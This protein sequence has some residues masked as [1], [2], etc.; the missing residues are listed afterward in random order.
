MRKKVISGLLFLVVLLPLMACRRSDKD[1]TDSFRKFAVKEVK[2]I[3]KGRG[4]VTASP[5]PSVDSD[6]KQTWGKCYQQNFE[7]YTIDVTK[8][9]SVVTPYIGSLTVPQIFMCTD[10]HPS[11]TEAVADN[12]FHRVNPL[13]L[14]PP[15]FTFQYAYEDGGWKLIEH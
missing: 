10:D 1:I 5:K 14:I 4:V 7:K 6:G 2:Q 15:T 3:N 8:T 12:Q 9:N 11:K 13:G